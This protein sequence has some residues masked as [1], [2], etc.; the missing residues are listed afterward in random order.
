MARVLIALAQ[1]D[2]DP[3][4]VAIPWKVL[5]AAG[6]E[7]RFATPEGTR[8]HADALMLTGEGLDPWGFVPG[9]KRLTVVGRLLGAR[10]DAREA[11]WAMERDAAFLSP[12]R[13]DALSADDF[14]ALVL[15]GGHRARGI[16]PYLESE[17]LRAFV[18]AM[19]EAAK[20]VGA[21]CHGVVV[22]ARAVSPTTGRS[23]LYGKKTTSLTWAQEGLAWTLGGVVRFW[24]GDYYRTYVEAPGEPAGSRGVEAEVTAALA[25]P[26]DYR[27]VPKSDPE[28]RRKTDGL[29]RD[30][31]DDARP[32]FVV[33]DGH[34]VSARW[35]GDA[36]TFAKTLADVLAEGRGERTP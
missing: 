1:Q 22:A 15:P 9:L 34:Y 21:I 26:S 35:P 10:R 6:H 27:D 12:R 3:T 7:V 13:F 32:A 16:R 33:R 11:W 2:A 30:T 14:D 18:V 19:F 4:E 25:S 24:D 36:Y 23:V 28:H 8:G 29:H 20:P 31:A 17:A 5:R